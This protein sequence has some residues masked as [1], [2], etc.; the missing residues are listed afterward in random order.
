M[1]LESWSSRGIHLLLYFWLVV[2]YSG[3][4]FL[5]NCK[6]NFGNDAQGVRTKAK[7]A[8]L[9]NQIIWINP[10]GQCSTDGIARKKPCCFP[11]P[12][13]RSKIE[14][15]ISGFSRESIVSWDIFVWKLFYERMFCWRRHGKGSF[16]KADT[17]KDVWCF[18]RIE[19][20]PHRLWEGALVLVCLAVPH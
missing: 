20:W 1:V 12:I 11:C 2:L 9:A 10:S 6:H 18:Q 13:L 19:I 17:W 5:F 8:H 4:I 15:V 3:K 14:V 16:A 7:D